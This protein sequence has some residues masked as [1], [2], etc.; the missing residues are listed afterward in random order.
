[1]SEELGLRPRFGGFMRSYRRCNKRWRIL[2][3]WRRQVRWSRS[4]PKFVYRTRSGP[5]RA[6]RETTGLQS[7][8]CDSAHGWQDRHLAPRQQQ[9]MPHPDY[10][11]SGINFLYKRLT[12]ARIAMCDIFLRDGCPPSVALCEQCNC[13]VVRRYDLSRK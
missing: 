11:I 6:L 12:A 13:R 3:Q 9:Y 8:V 10:V 2:P 7:I 1:V 4:A 5:E